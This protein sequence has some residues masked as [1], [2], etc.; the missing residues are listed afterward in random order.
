MLIGWIGTKVVE[1]GVGK[2]INEEDELKGFQRGPVP[3]LERVGSTFK[4]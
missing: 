4:G 3:R 2:E 1:K